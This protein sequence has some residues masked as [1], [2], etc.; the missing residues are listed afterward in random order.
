MRRLLLFC[1]LLILI[2]S[3]VQAQPRTIKGTVVDNA[4]KPL[5]GATVAVVET[6]KA[7]TTDANGNFQIQ[8]DNGQ[9]IKVTY[10]GATPVSIVVKPDSKDL[11]I[12][13][14]AAVSNLN[15][16]VV[17]GYTSERKKDLTGSVSVVDLSAVKN[18]SSGNTMEAL[19][20]RVAGLYVEKDGSVNGAT[21]RILIRG[22]NTLGNND[23][24]YIIDGIPTTRPEVF[25]S[26]SPANIASVQ[27]LKDASA[28]SI[29]GARASNGVI[30]VTTKTGGNTEGK[31][32]F[33]F[34]ST[35][36][37]ES[38]KSLR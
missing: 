24:L 17:T 19:Q 27:V 18:N 36:S 3:T 8:A 26:L 15:E 21:N 4:A 28:E 2:V 32:Q 12:Q 7:T 35:T 6:Q 16:L 33:Q 34:N 38:E 23:P 5:M 30:I 22:A 37:I 10:V 29:Y 20:G 11:Q 1:A 14:N 25:Q 31:V 13:I 9:T